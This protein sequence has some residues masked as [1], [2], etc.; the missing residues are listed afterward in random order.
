MSTWWTYGQ[1]HYQS[2]AALVDSHR[3]LHACIDEVGIR[4]D[5]NRMAN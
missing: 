2:V 5:S 4:E 3:A 1:V